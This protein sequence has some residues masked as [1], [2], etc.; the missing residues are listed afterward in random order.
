MTLIAE[1]ISFTF[2]LNFNRFIGPIGTF[3]IV[4]VDKMQINEFCHVFNVRLID[5]ATIFLFLFPMKCPSVFV[6][7]RIT[8]TFWI[9]THY[10]DRGKKTRCIP[11]W[12]KRSMY[13]TSVRFDTFIVTETIRALHQKFVWSWCLWM[14]I[15]AFY[16]DTL[17]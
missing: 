17:D 5:C 8:L 2:Q 11:F 14:L 1:L 16:H 7:N 9:R 13:S 10:A 4:V 3:L 12:W 6:H 15:S